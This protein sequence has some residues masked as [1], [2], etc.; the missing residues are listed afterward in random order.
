MHYSKD[1]ILSLYLT[2]APMGGI[3]EGVKWDPVYGWASP[4]V[5]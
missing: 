1:E 5:T 4:P 3:V 2:H